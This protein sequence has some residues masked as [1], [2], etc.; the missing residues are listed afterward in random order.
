MALNK[1]IGKTKRGIDLITDFF[2]RGR[3]GAGR[4]T[5]G[6]GGRMAGDIAESTGDAAR[7]GSRFPTKR[8]LGT[9]LIGGG[10]LF[11]DELRG[12]FDPDGTL[13]FEP[14]VPG[15]FEP[16]GTSDF[17]VDDSEGSGYDTE[18]AGDDTVSDGNGTPND[19][20]TG[21]DRDTYEP[22]GGLLETILDPDR[23]DK[24]DREFFKRQLIQNQLSTQAGLAKSRERS[25]REI[26]KERLAQWGAVTR[27][28][29]LRDTA[30]AQQAS[31]AIRSAFPDYALKTFPTYQAPQIQTPKR[32]VKE[33]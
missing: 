12:A 16:G 20:T 4:V 31:T 1:K 24:R 26:E 19:G 33:S 32:Y 21:L 22:F 9:A 29:I 30:I 27:Q 5:T 6:R 7:V 2:G 23:Q 15:A 25:R 13:K 10:L 11:D 28:Q 14:N 18:G 3:R 17:P 8:I